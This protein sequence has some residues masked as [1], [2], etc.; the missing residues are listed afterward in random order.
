MNS[1][2]RIATSKL[3]KPHPI[4]S[5]EYF[6]RG[7]KRQR[8]LLEETEPLATQ[9]GISVSESRNVA[10]RTRQSG[11]ETGAHWV[12]DDRKHDRDGTGRSA[13]CCLHRR[14]RAEDD[15]RLRRDQLRRERTRALDIGICPALL[16][17]RTAAIYPTQSPQFPRECDDKASEFGIALV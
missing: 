3:K 2:R 7:R 16:D 17:P 11:D 12:A 1:R 10:A 8:D 15:V 6:G 14:G 13:Q 9:T 5:G 4:G